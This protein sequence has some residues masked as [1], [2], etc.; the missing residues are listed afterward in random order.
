MAGAPTLIAILILLLFGSLMGAVLL[1]AA[2][3]VANKILGKQ[4]AAN[5]TQPFS[6][7][8]ESLSS[9][10][11]DS[12]NPYS[13]PTHAATN[14]ASGSTAIPE[15]NF[16]FAIVIS[17]AVSLAGGVIGGVFGALTEGSEVT[18]AVGSILSLVLSFVVSA[19]ILSKLLPTT[20]GRAALVCVIYGLIAFAIFF[21]VGI[22]AFLAI[23]S[24]V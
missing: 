18:E 24:A 3:S 19:F 12:T 5:E 14:V 16:G 13:P 22:I 11:M 1:R 9:E 23:R 4:P 21:V 8:V 17:L 7:P 20:Y 10:P 15:P 6:E 2:I